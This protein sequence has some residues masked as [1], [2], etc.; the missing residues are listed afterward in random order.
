M[1]NGRSIQTILQTIHQ[2]TVHTVLDESVYPGVIYLQD[3]L[4]QCYMFFFL[5]KA[6]KYEKNPVSSVKIHT[7]DTMIFSFLRLP[8]RFKVC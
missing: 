4:I 3:K 1:K 2:T 5:S 6:G 8:N 7:R